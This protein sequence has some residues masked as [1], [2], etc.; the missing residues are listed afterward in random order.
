[1]Y[2][3]CPRDTH[4]ES[5]RIAIQKKNMVAY[6]VEKVVGVEEGQTRAVRQAVRVEGVNRRTL[7]PHP[8]FFSSLQ[9]PSS[10]QHQPR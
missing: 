10:C 1:M 3:L 9:T 6:P 7:E 5:A 2:P 4:Q 8:F